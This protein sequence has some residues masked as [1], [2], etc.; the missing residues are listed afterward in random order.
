MAASSPSRRAHAAHVDDYDSDHSQVIPETTKTA[1]V[2]SKRASQPPPVTKVTKLP[3][4]A[5]PDTASDS[6][7]SSRTAA[8]MNS[9]DSAKE[10]RGETPRK[11]T[12]RDKIDTPKKD[13]KKDKSDTPKKEVRKDKKLP[14]QAPPPPMVDATR[15]ARKDSAPKEQQ[16][17]TKVPSRA[18]SQ[19]RRSQRMPCQGCDDPNCPDAPKR[20]SSQTSR[21][22]SGVNVKYPP[23]QPMR[24][25]ENYN[26]Q[27]ANQARPR[28]SRSRPQSYH[29]GTAPETYYYASCRSGERGPPPSQSAYHNLPRAYP[30]SSPSASGYSTP[31]PTIISSS[32]VPTRPRLESSVTE[33]SWSARRPNPSNVQPAPLITYGSSGSTTGPSARRPDAFPPEPSP[34]SEIGVYDP[35]EEELDRQLMP[36]PANFPVR[37]SSLRQSNILPP[38]TNFPPAEFPPADFPPAD[39]P[40]EDYRDDVF[41]ATFRRPELPP[42]DYDGGLLGSNLRRTSSIQRRSSV[43]RSASSTR[44]NASTL[45][46]SSAS[47]RLSRYEMQTRHAAAER[48]QDA[49]RSAAP[50]QPDDYY[51]YDMNRSTATMRPPPAR[52]T[53]KARSE[54]S[55]RSGSS[56]ASLQPDGSIRL[57]VD[58]SKG[59]EFSG[60]MEGRTINVV[61]GEVVIGAAGSARETVYGGSRSS[62]GSGSRSVRP[63]PREERVPSRASG[64][65][66]GN[67]RSMF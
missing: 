26:P 53:S 43:P 14:V 5:G 51:P 22:D 1:N 57:R 15:R 4:A 65:A 8:T 7:Y 63:T 45:T 24:P 48:Y 23:R 6:G 3:A 60:D 52:G 2:A 41:A 12:K 13:P 62:G 64:S 35:D 18:A 67:R 44:T 16:S 59:I 38:P 58:T 9:A 20:T 27:P 31:A 40:P 54:R 33:P 66:S 21:L 25:S 56:R 29:E 42:E 28:P 32:S 37:R 19:N 61:P 50:A 46:N 30:Y 17:P 11:E 47:A 36:P 39:F 34:E 55:A 10:L 49:T